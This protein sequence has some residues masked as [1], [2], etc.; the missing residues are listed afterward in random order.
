MG[1]IIGILLK[2]IILLLRGCIVVAGAGAVLMLLLIPLKAVVGMLSKALGVNG[3]GGGGSGLGSTLVR[4]LDRGINGIFNGVGTVFGGV[5]KTA[6]MARD[7]IFGIKMPGSGNRGYNNGYDNYNNRYDNRNRRYND[8]QNNK[9]S[10]RGYNKQTGE[11]ELVSLDKNGK[12]RQGDPNNQN[13]PYY[14]VERFYN[15]DGF[16][17][18]GFNKEGKHKEEVLSDLI[19]KNKDKNKN[20]RKFSDLY[21]D[22][23]MSDNEVLDSWIKDARLKNPETWGYAITGLTFAGAYALAKKLGKKVPENWKDKNEVIPDNSSELSNPES[24]EKIAKPQAVKEENMKI[25]QKEDNYKVKK[26]KLEEKSEEKSDEMPIDMLWSLDREKEK[27]PVEVKNS[28]KD[29]PKNLV[30]NE[31]DDI[32]DEPLITNPEDYDLS[33]FLEEKVREKEVQ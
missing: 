18:F 20:K 2:G 3:S 29:G 10:R 26:E 31:I 1:S 32:D 28:E 16:D 30:K 8:F 7:K 33:D 9:D 4:G 12:V 17:Q 14:G 23:K 11:M 13:D 6:G 27:V 21:Q 19:N 22:K 15:E 24:V 5:T 25:I